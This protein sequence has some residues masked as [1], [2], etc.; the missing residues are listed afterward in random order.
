MN[1]WPRVCIFISGVMPTVSPKSYTYRPF[2]RLGQALGSTAM[3]RVFFRFV[4]L[5]P[6]EGE[7]RPGQVAPPAGPADHDVGL[8]VGLLELLSGLEADH[9]LVDQDVVE[10]AAERVLGVLAHRRVLDG[11]A[12]GDAE[13]SRRLRILLEDLLAGP[14]VGAR[15]GHD[16]SAPRLHHHAAVGLLVIGD[17][18]HVDLALEAEELAGHSQRRAPLAGARLRGDPRDAF[19]LV[20]VGLGDGRVGLVAGGRA[21]ALLLVVDGGR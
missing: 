15:A 12:D 3:I 16:L 5:L 19:L 7:A 13:G 11:L 1:V 8:V 18:D 6:A 2:V 9:A 20:V 14:G 17:L 10:H 21:S 4:S